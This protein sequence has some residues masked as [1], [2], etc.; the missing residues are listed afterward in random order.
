MRHRANTLCRWL[1]GVSSNTPNGLSAAAAPA[2]AFGSA[3]DGTRRDSFMLAAPPGTGA[4]ALRGGRA[5]ARL[6]GSR[7]RLSLG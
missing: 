1:L 5:A 3:E 6:A 2:Q 7:S 4:P